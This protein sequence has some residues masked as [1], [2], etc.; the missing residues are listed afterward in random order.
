MV[1][2]NEDWQEG[3]GSSL[4]S[5]LLALSSLPKVDAVIVTLVDLPGLTAESITMNAIEV[6]I[7]WY[8]NHH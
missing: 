7:S 2:V 6:V 5:G 4:R 8:A 3:M 1:I